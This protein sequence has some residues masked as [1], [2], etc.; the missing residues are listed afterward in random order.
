[1]EFTHDFSQN[2]K[3]LPSLF[4][5]EKDLDMMLSNYFFSLYKKSLEEMFDDDLD[6]KNDILTSWKN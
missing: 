2:L 4:C 3:F 1:M 5:S 6:Y